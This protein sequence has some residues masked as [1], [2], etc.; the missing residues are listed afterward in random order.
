MNKQESTEKFLF[1]GLPGSGKTTCLA[2]LLKELQVTGNISNEYMV[3]FYSEIKKGKQGLPYFKHQTS[4]YVEDI[5]SQLDQQKW[6][7]PTEHFHTCKI[8]YTYKGKKTESEE[9]NRDIEFIDCPGK[10]F[11]SAFCSE[12]AIDDVMA[13]QAHQ[14]KDMIPKAKQIFLFVDA[15]EVFNKRDL[16]NLRQ[17]FEGLF[18]YLRYLYGDYILSKISIII[19]K[20]ELLEGNV[21][22]FLPLFCTKFSNA[23]QLISRDKKEYD[24]IKA[25]YIKTLGS[26][27]FNSDGTILPPKEREKF[28]LGD[29][30]TVLGFDHYIGTWYRLMEEE[31]ERARL[32]NKQVHQDGAFKRIVGLYKTATALL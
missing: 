1:L 6:P 17:S 11:A 22:D 23:Y 5:I 30:A 15:N 31:E 18:E 10:A 12:Y 13:E 24:N 20:L 3:H 28:F 8:K 25:F 29:F 4:D 16:R 7:A 2:L 9:I 14:L 21:P 26:I 27:E 32:G 19:N